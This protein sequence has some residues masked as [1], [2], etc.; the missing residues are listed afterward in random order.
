M[1]I[2][3]DRSFLL[4]VSPRLQRFTQKK[5]NLYNFRCPFCGDSQKSKTKCRGFI[6]A[7]KNDYFFMC[8]NC[9]L[10][11]SFYN[12]LKKLDPNL[13]NEYALER[14]KNGETGNHNYPKPDIPEIKTATPVFKGIVFPEESNSL[15]QSIQHLNNDHIAKKYVIQRKIPTEFYCNLF[16]AKDY[17]KYVE[18][19]GISKDIPENDER[20][21]IPFYDVDGNL[22]G[23]QGRTLTNSK[24][25]YITIR[26]QEDHPMM[27]GLNMVDKNETIYVVEGPI[28][29]M[30][31]KNSIAVSSSNLQS[32]VELF[33]KSKIV[34]V[35]D[36]E[37]RNKEICKLIEQAIEDHFNVVIWPE[38]MDDK[39][40]NDMILNGFSC[41]D[42]R[43]II[44]KNTFVNLRAKMEFINWKKI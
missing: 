37:P 12:F 35:F 17:K 38:M 28:D 10:S 2:F 6:Y 29:S 24:S 27:Y 25:R 31:L 30:F 34:L 19:F 41:E 44:E 13:V 11:I 18:S 32:A 9:S 1:S 4:Q 23:F 7:K 22:V 5:D 8:H 20:L 42:V 33:D 40:V 16:Y 39:D 14:Y 26:L 21:I 43:D 36:N 3:I 15:I